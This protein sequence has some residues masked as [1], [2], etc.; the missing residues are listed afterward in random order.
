M[1]AVLTGAAG[2]TIVE[3]GKCLFL[4]LK[5]QFDYVFHYK[6]IVE[7]FKNKVETLGDLKNHV[8]MLVATARMRGELVIENFNNKFETLDAKKNQVERQVSIVHMRGEVIISEVHWRCF[9][10]W[11]S[12]YKIGRDI[13]RKIAVA[14]Q[15][16]LDGKFSTVS[17]IV[18]PPS[19]ELL[20]AADFV[21][22][23]STKSATEEVMKA[24]HDENIN[25]IRVYGMGGVGK[26]TLVKEVGTQVKRDK[27]FHEVVMVTVSRNFELKELQ[28]EIVEKL[29][30]VFQEQSISV[31]ASRLS[32]RVKQ[33][34][35]LLMILDDL[36][37]RVELDQV[38]IP[39]G[40]DHRG[41]K[42]LLTSGSENVCRVMES[43]VVIKLEVLSDEDSWALFIEK[44][45][46]SELPILVREVGRECGGLPIAIVTVGRALRD[47]HIL[48]WKDALQQLKSST[49]TLID[50]MYQKVFPSLRLSYNN[51]PDLVR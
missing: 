9:K 17:Y 41:L 21:A 51:L 1:E 11:Q 3:M 7:N 45:S 36:W 5:R 42:I 50:V 13:T 15:L 47:Q 33:E 37:E 19:M 16:I 35:T 30:L 10:K 32:K 27:L 25:M 14:D 34:K 46:V 38:A 4:P 22:F 43:Q 44:A 29:G 28:N 6:R 20:P 40:K 23:A 49:P 18:P 24:L 39:F 12:R 48:V 31:R 8:E 2:S 26:T